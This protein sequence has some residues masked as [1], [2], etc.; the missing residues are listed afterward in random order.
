VRYRTTGDLNVRSSRLARFSLYAVI[1]LTAVTTIASFGIQPQIAQ[2]FQ[3][4]PV[5]Y[6][7]PALALLGLGGMLAIK[8]ELKGFLASCVFLAGMLT[9]AAF[10]IFPYVLPSNTDASKGLTIWNSA[11]A[12]YGLKVGL[13]WWI[14]GMA[15]AVG[16]SF[17]MHRRFS[18][19]VGAEGYGLH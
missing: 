12:E 10:G 2:N 6:I 13:A 16:Y 14:P 11:P 19:K 17:H 15:L 9:S 18:G 3:K 8:D 4:Y 1:A 7:F 5:G